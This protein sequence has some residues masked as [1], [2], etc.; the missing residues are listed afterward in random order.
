LALVFAVLTAI[1]L[2][3]CLAL[4][5]GDMFSLMPIAV[6]PPFSPTNESTAGWW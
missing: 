6:F 4:M 1:T 5:H 3:A 2:G